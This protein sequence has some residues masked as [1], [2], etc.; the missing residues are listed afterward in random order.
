MV[1]KPTVPNEGNRYILTLLV[2]L[3][4]TSWTSPKAP[5]PIT[6]IRLKSS[7][8]IRFSTICS[9]ISTSKIQIYY[10][11]YIKRH[12]FLIN[13]LCLGE[14][15]HRLTKASTFLIFL[16][17]GWSQSDTRACTASSRQSTLMMDLKNRHYR[18]LSI[19]RTTS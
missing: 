16:M 9:E 15:L 14:Y 4:L 2:Y 5:R 10:F 8:F 13:D 6:L 3:C 18:T 12:Y 1:P 17:A 11:S 19:F 7:A